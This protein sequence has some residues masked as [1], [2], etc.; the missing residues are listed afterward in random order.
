M[1]EKVRLGGDAIPE[2]GF[3]QSPFAPKVIQPTRPITRQRHIKPKNKPRLG[4][5][6]TP[7]FFF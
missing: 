6:P 7:L 1:V 2:W 4:I 5:N 3:T